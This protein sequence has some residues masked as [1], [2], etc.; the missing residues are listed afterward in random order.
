MLHCCT[1]EEIPSSSLEQ[2]GTLLDAWPSSR[3]PRITAV[4]IRLRHKG[5]ANG[6][7][8]AT[9]KKQNNA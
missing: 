4:L 2:S 1:S 6:A 5:G 9:A 3:E 8:A 7:P